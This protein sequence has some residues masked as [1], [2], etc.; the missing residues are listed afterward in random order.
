MNA[1]ERGAERIARDW[2]KITAGERVVIL[3]EEGYR[4]Q[5]EALHRQA[6]RFGAEAETLMV[7]AGRG[8]L[9]AELEQAGISEYIDRCDTVIGATK[10]SILTARKIAAAVAEGKRFLSLPL[11]TCSGAEM[12]GLPFL[13]MPPQRASQMAARLLEGLQ[14]R[15][16]LRI[17]TAMGTDL[18]L[19]L[20]GRRVGAFTGDFTHG[21]CCDSSC[22]E[23][24]A[25]P[26]EDS[27]EGVLVV[28]AS[29]GYIA[30]PERPVRLRFCGGKLVEIEKSPAGDRL[31]DYISAFGDDRMNVA[32]E[33]GI[34]LNTCGSCRGDCY[35]EDESVYGTFHVGMGRNLTFGGENDA[36]GHYDLVAWRPTIYADEKLI[37]RDGEIVF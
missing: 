31:R 23:V 1:V 14:G 24:F 18:R 9:G 22:F 12:L 15:N 11:F 34:G 6:E 3:S 8:Q 21:I 4:S 16:T 37:C 5:A 13:A 17:T 26:Q 28:D 7:S 33:L 20:A 35:I 2:L 27:A 19:S 36:V 29:F 30:A 25:A 32:G 10:Y